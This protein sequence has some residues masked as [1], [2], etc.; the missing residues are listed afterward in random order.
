M[1]AICWRNCDDTC[2]T[3]ANKK[4]HVCPDGKRR[5]PPTMILYIVDNVNLLA[6]LKD[7]TDLRSQTK[8]VYLLTDSKED[9]TP[10][11]TIWPRVAASSN[12]LVCLYQSPLETN[13]PRLTH[14]PPMRSRL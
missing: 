10:A 8:T 14:E 4:T 9:K 7:P 2:D 12:T 13:Y 11:N 5:F 3:Y 6:K 1:S